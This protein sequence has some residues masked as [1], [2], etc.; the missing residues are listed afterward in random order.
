MGAFPALVLFLARWRFTLVLVSFAS[1]VSFVFF[2]SK[3][4]LAFLAFLA[5]SRHRFRKRSTI[6]RNSAGFSSLG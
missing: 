2:V 4:F 1:F 3:L 5:V 6:A